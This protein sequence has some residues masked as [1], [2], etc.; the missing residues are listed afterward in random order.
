MINNPFTPM[1]RANAAHLCTLAPIDPAWLN[2]RMVRLLV[3]AAFALS[4]ACGAD[5][6]APDYPFPE[7]APLEETDLAQYVGGD[8]LGE[9][10]EEEWDDG[11]SD[12]DLEMDSSESTEQP[13][14]AEQPAA[15][16]AAAEGD[17]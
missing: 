7:Q 3:L 11:L 14:Q 2:P 6:P 8:D 17:S 15:E 16:P 13:E 9:E 4:F 12:E 5:T 10:E 1:R